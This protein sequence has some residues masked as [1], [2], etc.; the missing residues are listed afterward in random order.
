MAYEI[1]TEQTRRSYCG[2][3]YVITSFVNF[4]GHI[5]YGFTTVSDIVRVRQSPNWDTR[6]AAVASA[7]FHINQRLTEG[8]R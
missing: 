1:K 8:Y 5:K 7:E 3:Q 2:V 4:E 6:K